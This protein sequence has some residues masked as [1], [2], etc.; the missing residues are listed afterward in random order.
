MARG[1]EGGSGVSLRVTGGRLAGRRLRAPRSGLRPTGD[2]VRESLFA[3]LPDLEGAAVLDLF[4]GTGALGIEALSRGAASL[5]SVERARKAVAVL[6]ANVAAL[7]L[8]SS[9]RVM[10]VDVVEAV[11]RLG[12]DGVRFDLVLVDPPYASGEAKRALEALVEADVLAAGAVV[13]LERSRSHPSPFV[14]G[15]AVLDERRY[16]DTVITRFAAAVPEAEGSGTKAGGAR[17]P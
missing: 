15:L 14:A 3:R 8:D 6:R 10:A 17:S 5:V 1:R 12:L 11:R 16:G 9:T 4:A 7:R 2:R 13:V